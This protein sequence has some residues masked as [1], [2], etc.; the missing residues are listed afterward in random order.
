MK[1]ALEN[2][3]LTLCAIL[4]IP[5]LLLAF[6]VVTVYACIDQRKNW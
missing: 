1:N 6:V 3:L 2:T 5:I 4:C